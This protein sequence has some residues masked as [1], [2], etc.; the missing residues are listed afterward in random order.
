MFDT[1]ILS[2][3]LY[4]VSLS[5][6]FL[7]ILRLYA[8]SEYLGPKLLILQRMFGDLI[9]FLALFIAFWF[10]F[11]VVSTTF[12]HYQPQTS[13]APT[14]LND[15]SC[16]SSKDDVP[17]I[18]SL[19]VIN[20]FLFLFGELNLEIYKKALNGGLGD[21][22]GSLFMVVI[23]V[24]LITVLMLTNVLTAMF[25]SS[26]EGIQSKS[27]EYWHFQVLVV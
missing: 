7:R 10:A 12:I 15:L 13:Q 17:S 22:L 2:A 21:F 5:L 9:S 20:P 11:G 27:K 3:T 16:G 23:A 25:A 26:Y 24:F 4:S 19:M 8:G 1:A 6:Y 18:L 14:G